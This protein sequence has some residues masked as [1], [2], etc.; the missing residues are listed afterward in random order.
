MNK[1]KHKARLFRYIVLFPVTLLGL[2]GIIAS[3]GNGIGSV[4]F[5]SDR[6]GGKDQIY[7]MGADGANPTRVTNN[8]F[9]DSAPAWSPDKEQIAFV[10]H[11]EAQN[12]EIF[13]MNADGSNEQ[14]LTNHPGLDAGPAWA[15]DGKR[16]AFESDRGDGPGDIWIINTDT[17]ELT[18]VTHNAAFRDGEPTWSPDGTQIAFQRYINNNWEIC[19]I[20]ASGINDRCIT[21]NPAHDQFPAWS[22]IESG[23]VQSKIAFESNRDGGR[24]A[25][26]VMNPDGTGQQRLTATDQENFFAA[27]SPLGDSIVFE[28]SRDNNMEVYKMKSDGTGQTNISNNP[29][30]DGMPDW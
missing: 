12:D 8:S 21:N 9:S 15:P 14:R 23:S 30:K 4:V 24:L 2:A 17:G 7:T 22:P 3:N 13:I 10:R 20:A 29:A 1:H 27:W 18:N 25:I 28:S 5:V 6:A 16:I 19:V 26:Y 11:L